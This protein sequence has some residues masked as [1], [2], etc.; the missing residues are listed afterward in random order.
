MDGFFHEVQVIHNARGNKKE[1]EKKAITFFYGKTTT[2]QW[3]PDRWRWVGR[4]HFLD[5]T[6]K[7]GREYITKRT[8]GANNATEK[9]QGDLQRNYKFYWSPVWDPLQAWKEASFMWSAWHKAIAVNEWRACIAPISISKQCIF[10]LPN[11]GESIKHK[12][13]DCI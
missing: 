6:T 8:E 7:I 13:W 11:T 2:L 5:Y 10:C 12:L 4:C 3:D 1:G 9:W